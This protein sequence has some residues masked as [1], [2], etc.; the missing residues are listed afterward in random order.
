MVDC[1]RS[2]PAAALSNWPLVSVGA[3][4][5]AFAVGLVMGRARA[6]TPQAR[7]GGAAD[8]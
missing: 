3:L 4:L 2:W 5:A 1:R 7:E 6:M 8:G